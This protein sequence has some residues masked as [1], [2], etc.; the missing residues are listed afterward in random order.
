MKEDNLNSGGAL[1]KEQ[2]I[3]NSLEQTDYD[4]NLT[5]EEKLQ[6]LRD[7]IRDAEQN[8]EINSGNKEGYVLQK[9]V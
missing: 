8:L 4:D 9:K 5:N 7:L 3:N 1:K 6:Y 2:I